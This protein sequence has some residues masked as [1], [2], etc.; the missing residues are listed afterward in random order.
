MSN[1]LKIECKNPCDIEFWT[2]DGDHDA[3]LSAPGFSEKTKSNPHHK[4]YSFKRG[5]D[6]KLN[7]TASQSD[8]L[9]YKI[10]TE[11]EDLDEYEYKFVKSANVAASKLTKK[12]KAAAADT[13]SFPVKVKG[14]YVFDLDFDLRGTVYVVTLGRK[15]DTVTIKKSNQ[16]PNTRIIQLGSRDY[17]EVSLDK[18]DILAAFPP[19]IIA[20]LKKIVPFEDSYKY[21]Y[22]IHTES[23]TNLLN[24]KIK[25]QPHFLF[26]DKSEYEKFGTAFGTVFKGDEADDE[27]DDEDDDENSAPSAVSE[28]VTQSARATRAA[29]VTPAAPVTRV[30]RA[31]TAAAAAAALARNSCTAIHK[32]TNDGSSC[33]RDSIF[34]ALFAFPSLSFYG[35]LMTARP[36]RESVR[37]NATRL[38]EQEIEQKMREKQKLVTFLHTVSQTLIGANGRSECPMLPDSIKLV[39][40]SENNYQSSVEQLNRIFDVLE[41]ETVTMIETIT[42]VTKDGTNNSEP[43]RFHGSPIIT[44]EK[45]I[46]PN[47]IPHQLSHSNTR[48]DDL[49]VDGAANGV[50]RRT[51]ITTHV[52][53]ETTIPFIVLGLERLEAR[54]SLQVEDKTPITFQEHITIKVYGTQ[55]NLPLNQVIYYSVAH[56]T[57]YFRCNNNWYLYNDSGATITLIGTFAEM[58]KETKRG[59]TLLF[60]NDADTRKPSA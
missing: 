21:G 38:S 33:Y 49:Q 11:G 4:T 56:Y 43:R 46:Y 19:N 25:V 57:C 26:S 22:S 20:D 48:D 50:K 34:F 28:P 7:L 53:Y 36:V 18:Q 47:N 6:F 51:R 2:D 24:G 32:F 44:L 14:V 54:R 39:R 45:G 40:R 15:I 52:D 31:A 12:R 30:T 3:V 5:T 10:I 1:K 55:T 60:Y 8:N 23:V 58:L 59:W 27:D 13:D 9:K 17:Y 41:I 42:K 29:S 37:P 16:K 35:E